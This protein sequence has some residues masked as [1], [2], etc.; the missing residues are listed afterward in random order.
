MSSDPD[1]EKYFP[2]SVPISTTADTPFSGCTSPTPR[3]VTCAYDHWL[4]PG[5]ST[6]VKIGFS[7]AAPTDRSAS[8][9]EEMDVGWGISPTNEE[10]DG[11]YDNDSANYSIFFCYPQATDPK[12]PPA[13]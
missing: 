6:G 2:L 3:S 11:N 8:D 12:C 5:Q 10:R 1:D 9:I 4:A 7:V 13:T